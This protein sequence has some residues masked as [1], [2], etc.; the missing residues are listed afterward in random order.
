MKGEQK[1]KFCERVLTS[2]LN[3]LPKL[4]KKIHLTD[5]PVKFNWTTAVCK[6]HWVVKGQRKRSQCKYN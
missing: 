3:D 5:S 2:S 1:W 6:I 4:Y